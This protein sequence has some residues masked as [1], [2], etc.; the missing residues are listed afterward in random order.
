M[1]DTASTKR[2]IISFHNDSTSFCGFRRKGRSKVFNEPFKSPLAPLYE[3]GVTSLIFSLLFSDPDAFFF[4]QDL[5]ITGG[6][7]NS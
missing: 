5:K 7:R 6:H 4:S 3:G 2:K 1:V